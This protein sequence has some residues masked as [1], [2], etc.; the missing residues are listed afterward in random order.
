MKD[1]ARDSKQIGNII[2][3]SRKR[4]NLSQ[5]QLAQMTGLRQPTISSIESGETS[6]R[7]DTLL[8]VL[9]A[10]DLELH[11]TPRSKDW[12]SDPESYV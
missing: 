1:L 3:N 2:R 11:L 5:Q 4:L 10:L 9:A 8:T 6:A 12:S 7:I